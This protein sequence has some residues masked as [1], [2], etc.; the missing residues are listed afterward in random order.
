MW[1]EHEYSPQCRRRL[2]R[3]GWQTHMEATAAYHGIDMNSSNSS[4]WLPHETTLSLVSH[5]YE[6]SCPTYKKRRLSNDSDLTLILAIVQGEF[7]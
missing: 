6:L 5:R 4:G 3:S 7:L 1:R 2:I